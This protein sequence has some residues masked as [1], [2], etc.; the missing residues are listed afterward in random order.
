MH[1]YSLVLNT[2]K[3]RIVQKKIPRRRKSNSNL[4]FN[5]KV[6]PPRNR[7]NWFGAARY[8]VLTAEQASLSH[9]PGFLEISP[10]QACCSQCLSSPKRLLKA[11][12]CVHYGVKWYCDSVCENGE[13]KKTSSLHVSYGFARKLRSSP[14]L[15]SCCQMKIGGAPLIWPLSEKTYNDHEC[16][17]AGWMERLKWQMP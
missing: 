7:S 1:M 17:C 6:L 15:D 5:S 4:L 13:I 2:P 10:C 14:H 8:V 16:S 3:I 9:N 11:T 12:G